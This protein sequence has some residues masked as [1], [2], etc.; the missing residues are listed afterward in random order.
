[1]TASDADS[2]PTLAP[3]SGPIETITVVVPSLDAA[4]DCY[5][6]GVGYEVARTG[7]MDDAHAAAF[8]VERLAGAA[9]CELRAPGDPRP[10]SVVL[11]EAAD[12]APTRP[13]RTLGWSGIEF[14][15]ADVDA[16][17]ARAEAAGLDVIFPPLPVGSGGSLRAAQVAGAAGE[18]L[19]VTQVSG[20]PPG[21]DLPETISD[22]GRVF[23]AVLTTANLDATRAD[24]QRLTGARQV[25]DHDLP[26]RAVNVAH[27]LPMDTLH[28]VST[29]QLAG[30]AAIEVDR[31]AAAADE[32]RADVLHA[33]ALSVAVRSGKTDW[34]N[35]S[36]GVVVD[37]IGD[38]RG[39]RRVCRIAG[40]PGAF[41]ELL[42]PTPN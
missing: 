10:G 19:Y 9:L 11:V 41:L 36:D 6:S 23:I 34:V 35:A 38:G 24:V 31:Q 33:G 18:A 4:I 26:V 42:A 20:N 12:A 32:R 17:H 30:S 37:E 22:V 21:F 40:A 7:R 39:V 27:G 3:T 2:A 1:M 25:T 28:R 14:L 5:R 15:V 8:G 29:S 13:L 16:A